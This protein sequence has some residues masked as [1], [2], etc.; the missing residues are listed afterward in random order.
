MKAKYDRHVVK[1]LSS[2]VEAVTQCETAKWGGE[3]HGVTNVMYG[4]AKWLL[5]VKTKL[6]GNAHQEVA[7]DVR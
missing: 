4:T 6:V 5:N 1:V 7:L 2:F 3:V